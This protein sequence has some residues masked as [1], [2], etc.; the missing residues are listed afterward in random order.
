MNIRESKAVGGLPF[1][2]LP[3]GTPFRLR[4]PTGASQIYI[5]TNTVSV[6]PRNGMPT[7]NCVSLSNGYSS[8]CPPETLCYVVEGEFVEKGA[9]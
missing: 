1:S 5:K 2:Q 8:Y 6:A 9:E 4:V 3:E 7:R